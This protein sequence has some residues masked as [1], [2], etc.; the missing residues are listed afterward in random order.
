MGHEAILRNFNVARGQA[1]S[2]PALEPAEFP[3]LGYLM[4]P[5]QPWQRSRWG[6]DSGAARGVLTRLL[7]AL[8][9]LADWPCPLKSGI[10][11]DDNPF[12]PSGYTYLMQFVVRDLA[13]TGSKLAQGAANGIGAGDSRAGGMMLEALYG[14]GQYGS[15]AAGGPTKVSPGAG[16][17]SPTPRLGRVAGPRNGADPHN[18]DKS[19][20]DDGR[21]RNDDDPILAQ[22]VALFSLAHNTIAEQVEP[23][24]PEA[25]F[26]YARAV[27][28]AIYHD[29]IRDDLLPRLLHPAV[30]RAMNERHAT[31][32]TWLW[33]QSGLP[34]EFSHSAFRA[35]HAAVRPGCGQGNRPG[36]QDVTAR[37]AS[38]G[39]AEEATRAPSQAEWLAQWSRLFS[40]GAAPDYS[41][42]ISPTR[43][44]LEFRDL[45]P[46]AGDE[47]DGVAFRDLL[48]AAAAHPWSVDAMIATIMERAPDLI[49]AGWMFADPARRRSII[50]QWLTKVCSPASGLTEEDIE[51]LA[52]DPPLP[53]FILLEAGVDRVMGGRCLGVL[54]SVIV[55]EVIFK[56]LAGQRD[57][58][59][60]LRTAAQTALPA[61][62]A[63]AVAGIDSMPG[64]VMFVARFAGM[65][66]VGGVPFT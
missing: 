50:A 41:R 32:A 44:S 59:E 60:M 47:G 58:L 36:E 5:P 42:R 10:G 62:L 19:R 4:G 3:G 49:P 45:L 51:A 55:G 46:D 18:G 6:N 52:D 8:P 21:P 54:G 11:L 1:Q 33:Q 24:R 61:E 31:S 25:R 29:I 35:S 7:R 26:V 53:L 66:E 34:L 39:G 43:A 30:W 38:G 12:I 63:A 37:H 23:V 22:F 16:G 48:G 28:L 65:G 15:P 40:L 20:K 13:P 64:L 9:E 56:R 27:M 57:R 14:G 17:G 2:T